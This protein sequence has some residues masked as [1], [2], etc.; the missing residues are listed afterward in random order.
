MSSKSSDQVTG[1]HYAKE[2]LA[3]QRITGW[4]DGESEEE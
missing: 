3:G 2:L 4:E 1:S